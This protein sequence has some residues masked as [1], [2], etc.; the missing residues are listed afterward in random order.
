MKLKKEVQSNKISTLMLLLFTMI[1]FTGCKEAITEKPPAVK[2]VLAKPV[3][4]LF[5]EKLGVQGNVKPEDHADICAR[6]DGTLNVLLVSEGDYVKKGQLLFQTDKINLE[7]QIE[8]SGQSIKVAETAV[9]RAEVQLIRS[10]IKLEKVH[11][12]YKRATILIAKNAISKTSYEKAELAW[13]DSGSLVKLAE[14]N[15]D[16]S[17]ASLEQT[18]GNYAI[19]KKK[20]EDSMVRAPFSGVIA[21]K[22]IEEGEYAR[23]GAPIVKL[24]NPD[25]LETSL[26]ISSKYYNRIYPGKTPAEIISSGG[27]NNIMATVSYRSPSIDP[28]TRTFEIKINLPHK[29]GFVS[30]MLCGVNL[31]LSSH[32]A[33]GVPNEAVMLKSND[34]YVVF[35]VVDDKAKVI[36]VKPGIS[37]NKFTELIDGKKLADTEIVIQGQSFLNNGTFVRILKEQNGKREKSL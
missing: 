1:F 4:M 26:L 6:I 9:K 10:K 12:D 30:G 18:K 21:Y 28:A 33:Y 37:D 29:N 8:I 35:S 34:K 19:T 15:L 3:Y 11:I 22:Y 7:N 14:A 27:K 32:E 36:Q 23:K 17:K 2:V 5:Q 13:K 31:I 24:E 16:H 20:L 25:L